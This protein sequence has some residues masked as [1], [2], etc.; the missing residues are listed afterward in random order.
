[1]Y[2]YVYIKRV[3]LLLTFFKL[4]HRI[5]VYIYMHIFIFIHACV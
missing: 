5:Y 1:M 4:V 2:I 3:V